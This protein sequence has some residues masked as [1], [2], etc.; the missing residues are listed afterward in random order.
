MLILAFV[1]M[2]IFSVFRIIKQ[3]NERYVEMFA[4]EVQNQKSYMAFN[5]LGIF[6]FFFFCLVR[7]ILTLKAF[8]FTADVAGHSVL[9]MS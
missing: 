1:A 9:V 5:L 7:T 8:S 3:I 6:R 4:V 2:Y